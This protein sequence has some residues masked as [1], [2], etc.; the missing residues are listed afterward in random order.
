MVRLVC[1]KVLLVLIFNLSAT[2]VFATDLSALSLKTLPSGKRSL[3]LPDN[4]LPT[5]AMIYQPDC[6]WCKQQGKWLS[7]VKS[8]CEHGVNLRLI[9]NNGS[10]RELKRELMYFDKS[11]PAF[12]ASKKFLRAIGGVEA[13]PTTLF[14]DKQGRLLAKKRGY[15]QP[16]LLIT[17]LAQLTEQ[18][19]TI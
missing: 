8:N 5:I 17:A 13:S 10:F 9:G 14:F 15:I 2:Q 3:L 4:H 7:K 12:H 19:C 6:S 11:L 18:Q 16:D 1:F